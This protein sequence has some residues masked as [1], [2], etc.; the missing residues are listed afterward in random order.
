MEVQQTPLRTAIMRI[1]SDMLDSPDE[2]GIFETGRFM[3][4]IEQLLCDMMGAPEVM[5]LSG[6]EALFGLMGWLTTRNET[7]VLGPHQQ[8][9]VSIVSRFM[10]ANGLTEPRAAWHELLTHPKELC[11]EEA[12]TFEDPSIERDELREER[13][14]LTSE[15]DK[16]AGAY[17]ELACECDELKTPKLDPQSDLNVDQV[18]IIDLNGNVV[19]RGEL[20]EA[21][22]SL[23][24]L[25]KGDS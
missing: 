8:V 4:R 24:S 20:D 16:L 10:E 19:A 2:H 1:M 5:Q 25:V 23:I 9:D 11:P 14:R 7:T 22:S 12:I 15:L 21:L 13:K 18:T 17:Q 6:S 3:D